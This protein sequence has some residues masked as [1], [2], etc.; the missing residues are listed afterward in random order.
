MPET[1]PLK[2]TLDRAGAVFGQRCGRL[3]DLHYGDATREYEAL[4][5][6][7]GLVDAT[8]RSQVRLTGQD[9][10][11]FLHNM[12]TN[13]IKSLVSGAGC[14]AFL[15]DPK[16]HAMGHVYVFYGDDA[17]TLESA[18]GQTDRI[19]SSL[20]KYLIMED[21]ELADA[22]ADAAEL[23]VAGPQAAEV[24]RKL[25]AAPLPETRLSF[26]ETTCGEHPV[27]VSRVDLLPQSFLVAVAPAAVDEAWQMLVAAGAT[28]CGFEAYEPA[29]IEAGT[30]E[31]GRDITD[32]NLPQEVD[33]NEQAISFTKGCYIGQ[34]TVA[35]IDALG[36]VNKLLVGLQFAGPN[37]P[38]P[39][40]A[41]TS[42]EK[43]VGE[44]TTASWSPRAA[45]PVALGYV[46]RGHH[47]PGT[48][49]ASACGEATVTSF[50]MP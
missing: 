11:S 25:V 18:P 13:D 17:L 23:L 49:L 14:E 8:T 1:S 47:T 43:S 12:C 7:A 20:D 46:R 6:A 19:I 30:P 22:A 50:P 33:R 16:G 39:G 29:R 4:T 21:V 10:V 15:L 44:V 31:Y 36:H 2:Q 3:V 37:V 38:A 9:R 48:K 24:L 41:L 26:A 27:A 5:Q 32:K 40:T 45:A 28:P 42:D 34:E 35:R